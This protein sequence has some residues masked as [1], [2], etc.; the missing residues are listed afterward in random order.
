M[1][2]TVE[3]DN[4]TPKDRCHVEIDE[5]MTIYTIGSLKDELSPILEEFK[6]VELNLGNIED[7]DS[8][9]VQL[10][11]S[12]KAELF[13]Q[14]KQLKLTAVSNSVATLLK[15]YGFTTTSFN[16]GGDL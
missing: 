1:T 12:M 16:L 13:R 15:L 10:L 7:F 14:N 5:E 3:N 9:G 4:N 2:L 6:Q 11:L 8:A